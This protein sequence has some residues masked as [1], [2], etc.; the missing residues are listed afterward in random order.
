MFREKRAGTLCESCIG[1]RLLNKG[2]KSEAFDRRH[3][4]LTKPR[5]ELRALILCGATRCA[6]DFER[7]YCSLQLFFVQLVTLHIPQL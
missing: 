2:V 5:P 4:E 7:T 1:Y 3:P 6:P